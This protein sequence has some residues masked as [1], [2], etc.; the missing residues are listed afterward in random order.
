MCACHN[1]P[2]MTGV[3]GTTT[4]TRSWGR[5]E[6]DPERLPAGWSQLA[7]SFLGQ[8]SHPPTHPP[9][10]SLTHPLT[11]SLTHSPTQ[12]YKLKLNSQSLTHSHTLRRI[13]HSLTHSLTH[14]R[15]NSVILADEMGLGKTIQTISFLH[16]LSHCHELY[17]PFLVVVPLSTMPAWHREFEQ[18]T[19]DHNLVVY[20]GDVVSRQKVRATVCVCVCVCV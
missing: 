7:S 8:V 5:R 9:T 2:C 11:H 6:F 19:P 13:T 1:W 20:I 4:H 18:W 16:Y 12:S 15:N 14:Y 17:G 3:E 10:H